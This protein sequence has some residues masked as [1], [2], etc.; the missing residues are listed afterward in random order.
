[1]GPVL[2]YKAGKNAIKIQLMTKLH[3]VLCA[4]KTMYQ[5]VS[6]DKLELPFGTIVQSKSRETET[7]KTSR[8]FEC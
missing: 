1:M 6:V 7:H 5:N 4:K 8:K 3:F 2:Q